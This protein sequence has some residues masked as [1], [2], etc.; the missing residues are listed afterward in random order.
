MLVDILLHRLRDAKE[1]N[2]V[3]IIVTALPIS[4][5]VIA[6]GHIVKINIFYVR[7]VE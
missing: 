2:N 4:K 6:V 7:L 3:F 5:V 1:G